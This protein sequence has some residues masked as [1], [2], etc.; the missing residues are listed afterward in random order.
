MQLEIFWCRGC[1]S[2]GL[3]ASTA[4]SWRGRT[5]GKEPETP[6]PFNGCYA[7]DVISDNTKLSVACGNV[8]D[9]MGEPDSVTDI[10]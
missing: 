4:S 9:F 7:L 8:P 6:P 1:P 2:N 5:I 3:D 10:S